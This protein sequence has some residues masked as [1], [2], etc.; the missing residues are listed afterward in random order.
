MNLKI[1]LVREKKATTPERPAN[2]SFQFLNPNSQGRKVYQRLGVLRL[3]QGPGEGNS[4]SVSQ[5]S[6]SFK[7]SH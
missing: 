6:P 5:V 3:I 1:I 4:N 7:W 2:T